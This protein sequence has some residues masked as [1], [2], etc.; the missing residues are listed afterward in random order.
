MRHLEIRDLW[1]Q[2]EVWE[3]KVVVNKILGTE[4]PTD[5]MT[6][7]LSLGDIE[8]R[9]K[10]TNLYMRKPKEVH[11]VYGEP[12]MHI[13]CVTCSPEDLAGRSLMRAPTTGTDDRDKETA[14]YRSK[15]C[16]TTGDNWG[17]PIKTRAEGTSPRTFSRSNT[18]GRPSQNRV[19]FEDGI[20]GEADSATARGSG[21]AS[22]GTWAEEVRSRVQIIDEGPE[23]VNEDFNVRLKRI[24]GKIEGKLAVLNWEYLDEATGANL[25][26]LYTLTDTMVRETQEY[27]VHWEG[28]F[29]QHLRAEADLREKKDVIDRGI[30]REDDENEWDIPEA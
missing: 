2:K 8:D 1:L 12:V 30:S 28:Q 10:G 20:G 5:L 3:G 6:K 21:S 9:L 15:S 22:Q 16:R 27:R 29:I 19:T 13:C 26:M 25:K 17:P 24:C 23:D 4:N 7:I 18:G 14:R 11:H